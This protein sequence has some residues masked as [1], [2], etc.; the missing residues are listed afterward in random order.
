M[1]TLFSLIGLISF[2][3]LTPPSGTYYAKIHTFLPRSQEIEVVTR[4]P[5]HASIRLRGIVNLDDE[6]TFDR[7]DGRWT[8]HFSPRMEAMLKK[9]RC[10]MKG[11]EY[12]ASRDEASI[13]L[14][15]PVVGHRTIQLRSTRNL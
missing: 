1:L 14:R 4:R 2:A 13:T 9:Y 7:N 15:L 6:F 12:N 5:W 8:A 3:T 10:H 11:F